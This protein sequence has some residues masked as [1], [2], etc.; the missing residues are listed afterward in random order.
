MKPLYAT[1]LISLC[2]T[3]GHAQPEEHPGGVCIRYFSIL[4]QKYTLHEDITTD[5]PGTVPNLRGIMRVEHYQL[6]DKGQQDKKVLPV[7]DPRDFDLDQLLPADYSFFLPSQMGNK[8][9]P[10][11]RLLCIKGADTMRIDFLHIPSTTRYEFMVLNTIQFIPGTFEVDLRL[12]TPLVIAARDSEKH[13]FAALKAGLV[14]E[15]YAVLESTGVVRYQPPH[16]VQ[17]RYNY[18]QSVIRVEQTDINTIKVIFNGRFRYSE[19]GVL[20]M[21]IQQRMEGK[22]KDSPFSVYT[23]MNSINKETTEFVDNKELLIAD[24]HWPESNPYERGVYRIVA[25]DQ[26]RDS[27]ISMPFY[28]GT[29]PVE[30]DGGMHVLHPAG[31][32]YPYYSYPDNNTISIV[33]SQLPVLSDASL[34]YQFTYFH[35]LCELCLYNGD[36]LGYVGQRQTMAFYHR[37]T[38]NQLLINGIPFTGVASF[39]FDLRG[40]TVENGGEW[41]QTQILHTNTYLNGRLVSQ[42]QE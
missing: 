5:T 20:I 33:T 6:N 9:A 3:I 42:K 18:I 32:G 14:P 26:Q 4:D 29:V 15:T 23:A 36:Y 30:L 38:Y 21:A 11:Q 13:V 7:F 35:E 8:Y 27:V 12:N 39:A 34:V 28:I 41:F 22:W 1:L 16:D 40:A 24:K 31:M 25:F 2:I 17:K 19:N 37:L 10:S